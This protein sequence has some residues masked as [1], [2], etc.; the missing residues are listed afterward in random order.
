MSTY[1]ISKTG[2]NEVYIITQ[3]SPIA[4]SSYYTIED[5][6]NGDLVG[7]VIETNSIPCLNDEYLKEIN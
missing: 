5:F 4:I 7:E 6:Q 2:L 1:I 3:E